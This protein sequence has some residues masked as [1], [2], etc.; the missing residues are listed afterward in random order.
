VSMRI[1]LITLLWLVSNVGAAES[2]RVVGSVLIDSP[3]NYEVTILTQI[4]YRGGDSTRPGHTWE[5]RAKRVKNGLDGLLH[6]KS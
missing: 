2:S 4:P 3:N 1:V 6:Q 5:A